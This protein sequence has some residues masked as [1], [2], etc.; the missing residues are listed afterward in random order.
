M[1]TDSSPSITDQ[2][3]YTH[4]ATVHS[5]SGSA[6][7]LRVLLDTGQGGWAVAPMQWDGVMP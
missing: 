6:A 4:P 5:A 3:S 1:E 2:P 7:N